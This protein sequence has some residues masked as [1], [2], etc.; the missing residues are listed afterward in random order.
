MFHR[1]CRSSA[2]Q[3]PQKEFTAP[4]KNIKSEDIVSFARRTHTNFSAAVFYWLPATPGRLPPAYVHTAQALPALP[5]GRPK[6]HARPRR[7]AGAIVWHVWRPP[8]PGQSGVQPEEVALAIVQV[9]DGSR[10]Q[11]LQTGAVP[12]QRV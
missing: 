4:A 6:A 10:H 12:M 1:P 9:I 8:G 5:P 7:R 11:N 3:D 2:N